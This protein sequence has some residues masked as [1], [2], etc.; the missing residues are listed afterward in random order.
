MSEITSEREVLAALQR[1]MQLAA[2]KQA[3]SASNLANLNTPGY[4]AQE[5]DFGSTL[6][7]KLAA[8]KRRMGKQP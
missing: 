6:E 5:A 1:Q 7:D 4:R 3:V 2:A 8:L